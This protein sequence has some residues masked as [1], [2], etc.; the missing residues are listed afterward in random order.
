MEAQNYFILAK[1]MVFFCF[2]I[3]FAYLSPL[4]ISINAHIA[5]ASQ[6]TTIISITTR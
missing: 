2:S 1:E 6:I 4:V 3:Q 5:P